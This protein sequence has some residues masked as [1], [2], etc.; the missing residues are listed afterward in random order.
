MTEPRAPVGTD[1]QVCPAPS[2]D[3]GTGRQA[4]HR[5]SAQGD[6]EKRGS[7]DPRLRFA[8]ALALAF[9]GLANFASSVLAQGGVDVRASNARND[10]PDGIVFSLDASSPAGFDDVRLI[11]RIAPDGVRTTAIPDCV[12]G[13]TQSCSFVLQGGQRNTLI[14]GAEVTYFWRITSAGDTTETDAQRFTYE[15]TR[16]EWRTVSEGNVTVHYYAASEE[17]ARGILAAARASIEDISALLQVTVDFPVKVR[18]YASAQEMQLAIASDNAAGVI[19]LGEVVYS[20]TAM[21]SAGGDAA[22]IARHEV[23]HIVV[24]VA[25]GDFSSLPD[26]LNEGTAV[27]AQDVPLPGEESALGRAID[28]DSVFTVRQLSSAS[29]GA[30]GSRVE[31]FY[32]Q[33]YSIV[34]FLVE[35]YGDAKFAE[36]FRAFNDGATTAEALEQVYGFDQDGLYNE[37]RASVGL[38]PFEAPTPDDSAAVTP[39]EPTPDGGGQMAPSGDDDGASVV[40]IAGIAVLTVLLA[41]SLVGAGVY[42]SRRG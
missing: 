15:D 11:Y 33:S 38:P 19:T 24:R 20:D 22:D 13:T 40:L 26:W 3:A 25:A 28:N 29:S 6:G 23:A 27:F 18:Y 14:P 41:G 16:F 7:K 10:F 5:H 36:L 32:G 17:E 31:L 8:F 37:W 30:L 39:D 35:E 12:G 21:V 2:T 1:L 34:T 4:A 42:L 9:L